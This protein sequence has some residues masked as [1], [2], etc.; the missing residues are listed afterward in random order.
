MPKTIDDLTEADFVGVD[1]VIKTP[2]LRDVYEGRVSVVNYILRLPTK[3][4]E[5]L[6][7]L[8]FPS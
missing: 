3:V 8:I 6:Y 5:A 4:S 1:D 7:S 2:T